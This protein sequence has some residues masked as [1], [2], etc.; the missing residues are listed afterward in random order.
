MDPVLQ[1]IVQSAFPGFI[2]TLFLLTFIIIDKTFPPR[3]M[4]FFAC[5]IIFAFC[6]LLC[7][8]FDTYCKTKKVWLEM[9]FIIG[10]LAY[11]F[12]VSACV[13]T[14]VISQNKNR[15]RA[16]VLLTLLTINNV[17][18]ILNIWT[19]WI[20]TLNED[21][22]WNANYLFFE[23]YIVTSLSVILYIRVAIKQLKHNLGESAIVF[24]SIVTCSIANILEI[25][26]GINFVLPLS[27]IICI[28]FYYLCLNVELYRRDALTMLFNRRT[29][30]MDAKRMKKN[31]SVIFLSMD[32][33]DLKKYNDIEGHA[34]GDLALTTVSNCMI[35]AFQYLAKIYRTGGDEFIAVFKNKT[36]KQVEEALERF[37]TALSK[38]KYSVAS[39]Y[40]ELKNNEDFEKV[41]ALSD[42][43]MYENKRKIKGNSV[44]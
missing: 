24:A 5:A 7:D 42:Q 13:M 18:S 33:N 28:C 34:A 44:R 21:H 32:L 39:G 10:S 19:G 41:L 1:S 8:S 2:C 30:Y 11:M 17:V 36:P 25:I 22:T 35:S 26:L 16:I 29:F 31:S 38:T 9:R 23:P 20:F 40:A 12:R 43:R 3:T 27:L 15:Q 4:R 14:V 6:L 37:N